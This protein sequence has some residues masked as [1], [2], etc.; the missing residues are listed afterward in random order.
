MDQLQELL[1]APNVDVPKLSASTG[2]SVERL[3]ALASGAEPSLGEL[4]KLSAAL[5][6]SIN[7]FAPPNKTE[8]DV[9][10]LFRRAPVTGD[11]VPSTAILGM[12]KK[13]ASSLDLLKKE[14]SRAPQ[15]F[16]EFK[17]HDNSVASAEENAFIFRSIFCGGDQLSPLLSLPRIAAEHMGA[18][19]FVIRNSDLDGASAYFDG[20]P[21]IFVSARFRGRMLFTLA[22]EIGHLVAHH[23]PAQSFAIID[24][25]IDVE[26]ANPSQ[27]DAERY[28]D[29]FASALLMPSPSI[30]IALKKIRD[31]A[32]VSSDEVGDLELNYLARIYGVS[33]WAAAKRCEDLGIIPRGG[34]VSLNDY[35]KKKYGSAEKRAEE[36]G[37]PPRPE[38]DFPSVPR[39]LLKSAVE[40]VRAG[41]L[42]IGRAAEIIGLSIADLITANAPTSH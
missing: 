27:P 34:A 15:W 5:R 1:Q 36:A 7:D 12:S 13:M 41:E 8:R 11:E 37:L 17:H 32:K 26:G 22:H 3:S 40:K 30:G 35:V 25:L 28:A 24:E 31:I 23:D 2:I 39:P 19:V 4:R 42:S 18:M 16:S 9:N 38:I 20:L 14:S 6:L 29:A 10:L 21:F 33:F